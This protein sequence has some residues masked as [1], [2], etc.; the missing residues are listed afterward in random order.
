MKP[1]MYG[2]LIVISLM[3]NGFPSVAEAED[4]SKENPCT[5]IL[6]ACED[7]GYVEDQVADPGRK[8]WADCA[9]LILT[10]QPVRGLRIDGSRIKLCKQYKQSRSG[11]ET[12]RNTAHE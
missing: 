8:I 10:N 4:L 11:N 12:I 9:N 2:S 5:P 6:L 3:S 1:W 7:K